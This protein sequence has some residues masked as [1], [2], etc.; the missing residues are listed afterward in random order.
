MTR[1]AMFAISAVVVGLSTL[2]APEASAQ[3]RGP[4]YR[5]PV[6]RPAPMPVYRPMPAPMY[7]PASAPIYRPAPIPTY[8]PA[9]MPR[10]Q[11][12]IY[13]PMAGSTP[14][15][16]QPSPYRSTVSQ[17]AGKMVTSTGRYIGG[18]YAAEALRAG[19]PTTSRIVSRLRGG[20]L[21]AVLWPTCAGEGCG[22]IQRII[23]P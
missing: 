20:P 16:A 15:V 11:S 22:R 4:V 3:F 8:R 2:N 6:Y 19:Y 23:F 21:G 10:M 14:M 12:N 13:G 9:L 18:T 1:N 7:R 17:M 5:Q